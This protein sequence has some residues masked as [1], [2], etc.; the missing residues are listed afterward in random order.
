MIVILAAAAIIA[1]SANPPAPSLTSC[2]NFEN[3]RLPARHREGCPFVIP[4]TGC[5]HP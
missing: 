2:H 3:Q 1:Q 5:A 4:V